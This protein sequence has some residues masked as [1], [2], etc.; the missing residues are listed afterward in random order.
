MFP[1]FLCITLTKYHFT[2]LPSSHEDTS[3]DTKKSACK[4][5]A[6][7]KCTIT[8]SREN[9]KRKVISARLSICVKE[10]KA[11]LLT[12]KLAVYQKSKNQQTA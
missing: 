2:P 11:I 4:E 5:K 3:Y 12:V 10:N 7:Q 9:T 1:F 8:Q 6:T